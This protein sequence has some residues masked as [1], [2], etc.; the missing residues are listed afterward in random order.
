MNKTEIENEMMIIKAV[1]RKGG[2]F[3]AITDMI[4]VWWRDERDY[5]GRTRVF[6]DRGNE[7]FIRERKEGEKPKQNGWDK[8]K[9]TTML[10]KRDDKNDERIVVVGKPGTRHYG[11]EGTNCFKEMKEGEKIDI[12]IEKGSKN[13]MI[14]FEFKVEFMGQSMHRVEANDTRSES[15]RLIEDEIYSK[16]SA[17]PGNDLKIRACWEYEEWSGIE[18][19][20][21]REGPAPAPRYGEV[22][23]T[24]KGLSAKECIQ[25]MRWARKIATSFNEWPRG[26]EEGK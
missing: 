4:P 18:P 2:K 1:I 5:S 26:E 7:L 21:Q 15:F 13:E 23:I 25:V 22:M 19:F 16:A 14:K 10:M 11:D 17:M 12:M 8:Y 20:S 24:R 6:D 9:V 3:T